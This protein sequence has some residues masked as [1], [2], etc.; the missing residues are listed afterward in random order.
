MKKVIFSTFVATLLLGVCASVNAQS[1]KKYNKEMGKVYK[2]KAK[3]L[4]K[5]KWEVSGTSLTLEVALMKHLRAINSDDKNREL[6]ATVSMCKSINV[7]KSTAL[8]NALIEYA[9]SAGSYVRGRVTSDM[10]NNSSA[11][12]PEE[13]DKFYAAYERLVSAEI[14]GELEF[15]FA[16]EKAN[17]AGK[18]Y[19]AYYIVNEEKAGKARQRA[20][21]RAFEE[22]KLAQDYAGKVSDFVQEGFLE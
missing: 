5:Q 17:G 3:L 18:S 11:D 14:K 6:V 15:S 9:Q 22:T 7:C 21:Q 10:F 4:K 19:Q 2:E 13:F 20:M 8:N 12:V 1:D 16:L